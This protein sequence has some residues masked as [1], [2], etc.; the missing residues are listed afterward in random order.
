MEIILVLLV[1]F[2]LGLFMALASSDGSKYIS[3][4]Y[5][6]YYARINESA[7]IA[8]ERRAEWAKED[9]EREDME[10]NTKIEYRRAQS[11]WNI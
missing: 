6:D 10:H 4:G 3:K 8:L 2:L 9:M 5:G 7:R 1:V 11:C